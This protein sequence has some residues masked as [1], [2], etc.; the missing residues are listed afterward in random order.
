MIKQIGS[1]TLIWILTACAMPADNVRTPKPIASDSVSIEEAGGFLCS[2]QSTNALLGQKATAELG[3][4]AMNL[5]GAEILRWVPPR[6]PITKDYRNNRIN[7]FYDDGLIV[8]NIY[9][10]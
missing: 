3:L 9:C 10:G 1:F 2:A 8:T 6:T 5:S 7:I 4:Q